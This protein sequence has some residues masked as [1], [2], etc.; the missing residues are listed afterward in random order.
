MAAAIEEDLIQHDLDHLKV[1]E[2]EKT[3]KLNEMKEEGEQPATLHIVSSIEKTEE[4]EQ[5][6]CVHSWYLPIVIHCLK[7]TEL[8]DS[9]Q[10]VYVKQS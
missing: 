8:S 4:V 6:G 10:M 7:F 9:V 3:D 1:I 5:S 2:E